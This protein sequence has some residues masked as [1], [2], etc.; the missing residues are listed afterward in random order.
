M[1][2]TRV[3]PVLRLSYLDLPMKLRQCFAYCARFPKGETISKEDLIEQWMGNRF[4]PSG[5]TFDAEDT[6]DSTWN[7]LYWRSLFQ[8]IET[9]ELGNDETCPRSCTISCKR[10]LLHYR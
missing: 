5:E 2:K 9:D 10:C 7:E 6:G 1:K 4:I 8:D 3:I